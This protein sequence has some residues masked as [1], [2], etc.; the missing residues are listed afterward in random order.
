MECFDIERRIITQSTFLEIIDKGRVE[1]KTEN[2]DI[3][4]LKPNEVIIKNEASM[5]S[6]GTELSKVFALKPGLVFPIRPGYGS[7]GRIL[8]KGT[9]LNNYAINDRVYFMGNHSSV[10]K[11]TC[12]SEQMW[13]HMFKVPDDM[14]PVEAA[15]ACL[16]NIALTATN[17]Q[18]KTR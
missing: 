6:A 16:I 10:Q 5:I 12:T 4:N 11:F 15:F 1:C 2:I 9:A 18:C 14:D 7:V 8:A 17:I 3:D 13:S